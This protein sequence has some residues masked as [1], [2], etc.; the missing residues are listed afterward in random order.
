MNRPLLILG[1][2][3]LVIAIIVA[4]YLYFAQSPAGVSSQNASTTN[5]FGTPAGGVTPAGSSPSSSA[6]QVPLSNGTSVA[7]PDFTKTNQPDW[8]GTTSGYRV[9]GSE[10]A[11]QGGA[12]FQILY[13]PGDG[14]FNVVLLDE[15]I[16]QMRLAAESALR[17]ALG[18]SSADLCKLRIQVSTLISVNETYAGQSLGLSFCPGAVKLPL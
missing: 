15:P 12:G 4:G 8:A 6:F 2:V 9:A 11:G 10:Q 18:L 7:V 14:S 13:Y 3:V 17:E 16:G 1:A 5:P